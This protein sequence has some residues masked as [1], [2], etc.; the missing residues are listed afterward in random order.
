M[1]LVVV[2]WLAVSMRLL[3]FCLLVIRMQT[4]TIVSSLQTR[5]ARLF[6]SR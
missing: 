5:G 3:S 1:R 2:V 4:S 6:A